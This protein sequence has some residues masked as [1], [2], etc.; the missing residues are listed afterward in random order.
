MIRRETEICFQKDHVTTRKLFIITAMENASVLLCTNRNDGNQALS[1]CQE[2]DAYLCEHCQVSH[3]DMKA[4]R[5]HDV[6]SV[7]DLAESESKCQTAGSCSLHK[8]HPLEHYDKDCNILI[9]YKCSQNEHKHCNVCDLEA[10]INEIKEDTGRSVGVLTGKI[11]EIDQLQQ[12]VQEIDQALDETKMT[13]TDVVQH[14]FAEMKTVLG[15]REQE[16][17]FQLDQCLQNV[18]NTNIEILKTLKTHKERNETALHISKGLLGV[19][20]PSDLF[21]L[22]RF[23]VNRT[24]LLASTELP[25]VRNEVSSIK[26][27]APDHQEIRR[28]ISS[29][30]TFCTTYREMPSGQVGDNT[31]RE[32]AE[33]CEAAGNIT[34]TYSPSVTSAVF[35]GVR[36]SFTVKF[37]EV[38]FDVH[39]ANTGK[40]E[41]TSDMKLS[42]K[43]QTTQPPESSRRL[44]NF[45]GTSALQ[46][47][48]TSDIQYWEVNADIEILKEFER[49]NALFEVGVGVESSIDVTNTLSRQPDSM[50]LYLRHCTAH[51]SLCLIVRRNRNAA[52]CLHKPVANAKGERKVLQYGIMTN[53]KD[54]KC[55][56]FDLNRTT[57][58]H[59]FE[60]V[61]FSKP[62]WPTFAVFKPGMCKAELQCISGGQIQLNR[63]KLD[64]LQSCFR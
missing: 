10:G 28:A 54:R 8:G 41:F 24:S 15:Q 1:W 3:E 59:T 23:I 47:V 37:L 17:K 64:L 42:R 9:C 25:L 58:L 27:S 44:K 32:A 60:H 2:C 38:G 39:R 57:V 6:T 45:S 22:K 35:T 7:Q 20:A 63:V 16:V 30:G 33:D 40:V 48:S 62:F 4:T 31:S 13:L 5:N 53:P 14:S 12:R 29:H 34:I 11:D 26:F 52:L 36:E 18:K 55:I 46:P 51:N 21:S 19:T 50:V 43:L 61:N 56:L 49:L